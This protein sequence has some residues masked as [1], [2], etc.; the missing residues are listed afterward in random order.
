MAKKRMPAKFDAELDRCWCN[1]APFGFG[2]M[3]YACFSRNFIG[4][5]G[6]VWGFRVGKRFEVLHSYVMPFARRQGV[7]TWINAEILKDGV[8]VITTYEGSKDGGAAFLRASGYTRH[9]AEC[10]WSF[11]VKR[12]QGKAIKDR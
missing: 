11:A 3:L 4:P 5:S 2:L 7:R 1:R 10:N 6:L 8:Q 9:K 12:L